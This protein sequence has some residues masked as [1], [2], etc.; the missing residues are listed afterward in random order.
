M[1]NEDVHFETNASLSCAPVQII[2]TSEIKDSGSE[3]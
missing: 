2:N 1:I 3:R